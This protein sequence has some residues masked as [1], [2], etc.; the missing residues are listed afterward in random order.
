MNLSRRLTLVVVILSVALAYVVG[1]EPA[2]DSDPETVL[3]K[4]VREALTPEQYQ[5]FADGAD[6]AS[7]VLASGETLADFL[8]HKAGRGSVASGLVYFPVPTC[9]VARERISADTTMD[10]VVRGS[11]GVPTEAESIVAILQAI[12]PSGS[13]R[14]KAW[15]ADAPFPKGWLLDY[16]QTDPKLRFLNTT[17]LDLCLAAGC[18]SD[19]KIRAEQAETTARVDVVGYFA[20]GPGGPTGATGATGPTGVTGP[21]GPAGPTGPSGGPIG[22]TGP[23][24]PP[25]DH[26]VGTRGTAVGT[27]ALTS[28]TSG[29]DNTAVGYRALYSNTD[30]AYNVGVGAGALYS[31]V[32]DIGNI[33]IGAQAL[34][35]SDGGNGNVAVGDLALNANTTGYVNVAVGPQAL[36]SNTTGYR[37]VGIGVLALYSNVDGYDNVGIGAG[38]LSNNT[39][40][41]DNVAIGYETLYNNDGGFENIAIGDRALHHNTS[42]DNNVA[43][44]DLALHNTTTGDDNVALGDR[45]LFENTVGDDNVAIGDEAL[46]NSTTGSDNIGIGNEALYYNDTGNYNVGIGR[47]ALYYNTSGYDN[48]AIGRY[49]LYDNTSGAEN[50]AIGGYALEINTGNGNIGLGFRAGVD[51]TT[52]ND[53]VFIAN[54]GVAGD[55][56]TIRIGTAQTATYV[57]GIRGVTTGVADAVTVM[58]DSAGQ[59]GTVSSSRRFKEDVRDMGETSNALLDLRP[60]TFRFKERKARGEERLEYGLIAE[61]VARVFPELVVFDGAGKP[62]TVRYHLLSSLLLNEFQKQND[63]LREQND[64]LRELRS[65]L[66]AVEGREGA[67]LARLERLEAREQR[68]NLAADQRPVPA[69]LAGRR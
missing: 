31:S 13:G 30:G 56:D 8:G 49:A 63:Q 42:G 64:Q 2:T 10:F 20:P 19:F 50:V 33:A 69:A 68:P 41:F 7:L 18:A 36:Y 1:G 11:C 22:P 46:R 12:S 60:V 55:S 47:N 66:A 15:A 35:N 39:D 59:L 32:S 24:G 6:P 54:A 23:T 16:G 53:N 52:G 65:R 51:A 45:T 28:L 14:L 67:L 57:A 9:E 44:G 62:L 58:I 3:E 26:A 4:A 37:N 25:S 34:F 21:T 27:D 61:E 17:V 48:V 5:A 29:A 38:A 43:L 40:G